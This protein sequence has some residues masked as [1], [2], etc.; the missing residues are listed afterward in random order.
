MRY[1]CKTAVALGAAMMTLGSSEAPAQDRSGSVKVV[2]VESASATKA[3]WTPERLRSA[4]PYVPVGARA[5]RPAPPPAAS[6][7]MKRVKSD[8]SPSFRPSVEP[9]PSEARVLEPDIVEKQDAGTFATKLPASKGWS[10]IPFTTTRIFPDSAAKTWPNSNVGKLFFLDGA[11]GYSCSAALIGPRLIVTAAHCIY[12]TVT[13]TYN[14]RFLFIPAW[15]AG[16]IPY[17]AWTSARV[18]V[19]QQWINASGGFPNGYDHGIIELNDS[20]GRSLGNNI[21]WLGWQTFATVGRHLTQIGYPVNLDGATRPILSHSEAVADGE[22]NARMGSA[23]G[24]G[25]AGGPWIKDFG[26]A[27]RGQDLTDDAKDGNQIVAVTSF[28]TGSPNEQAVGGTIL[29]RNWVKLWK[30]AC[31]DRAGNC[32]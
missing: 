19:P 26:E 11:L 29:K 12:N 13:N 28:F 14:T 7:Q 22:L 24:A 25:A 21:G 1:T 16:R 31:A 23:M 9:I 18:R 27:A 2:T 10:G 3:F 8:S 20:D 5:A 15:H 6:V 30:A 17:G 32:P 4:V